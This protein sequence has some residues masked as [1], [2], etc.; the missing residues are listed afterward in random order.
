MLHLS[1]TSEDAL[2]VARRKTEQPIVWRIDA[3]AA[4]RAG[5]AFYRE[6]KVFLVAQVPPP[7]LALEV[8]PE[9]LSIGPERSSPAA[10]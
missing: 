5:L 8:T 4:H 7:F 1:E 10:S 6:G 3:Q 9:R 2:A